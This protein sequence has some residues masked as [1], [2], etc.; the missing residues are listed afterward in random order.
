MCGTAASCP[1]ACPRRPQSKVLVV[2]Y[3]DRRM[4]AVCAAQGV[5]LLGGGLAVARFVFWFT[6]SFMII[7]HNLSNGFDKGSH[8]PYPVAKGVQLR[9]IGLDKAGTPGGLKCAFKGPRAGPSCSVWLWPGCTGRKVKPQK[10][11]NSQLHGGAG[12]HNLRR[13]RRPG[14]PFLL[15]TARPCSARPR[16][17]GARALCCR[18]RGGRAFFTSLYPAKR[19]AATR[20]G[21]PGS[22]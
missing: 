18:P 10:R 4:V 17:A 7:F 22:H 8:G 19:E 9:F 2:H 12:V 13:S 16:G 14:P 15:T 1:R 6:Q 5:E 3:E 11:R 21:D 20:K